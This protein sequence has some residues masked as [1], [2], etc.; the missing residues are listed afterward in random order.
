MTLPSIICKLQSDEILQEMF[1]GNC[2]G[3]CCCNW[4]GAGIEGHADGG[5][6]VRG[7]SEDGDA[8]TDR[9]D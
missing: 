6:G 9:P 8:D 1:V 3:M 7:P 4:S 2:G 5:A